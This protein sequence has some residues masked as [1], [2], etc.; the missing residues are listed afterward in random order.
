MNLSLDPPLSHVLLRVL[1]DFLALEA[2]L[3]IPFLYGI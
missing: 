3:T 2:W 1:R